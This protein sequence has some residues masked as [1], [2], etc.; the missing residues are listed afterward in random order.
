MNRISGWHCSIPCSPRPNRT[1]T[2]IYPLHKQ[3]IAQDPHFY[4]HLASWYAD[5]GDV[6]DHQEMF[7][8]NLC[9]SSFP[10]HR[11]I[12]LALLRRLPPYEVA[13]VVDFMKGQQVTQRTSKGERVRVMPVP[14]Q[15]ASLFKKLPAQSQPPAA[16][17]DQSEAAV[18]VEQV[19]LGANV[20]RSMRTE[21]ERYLREREADP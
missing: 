12:G 11:D 4:V 19:G 15:R 1:L 8:A 18:V 17:P 10:G 3:I 21:I 2:A 9:R 16:P 7:V 6:R 20:P 14:H 5:H 13:R